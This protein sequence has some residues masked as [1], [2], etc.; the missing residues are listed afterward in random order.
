[1]TDTGT[2]AVGDFG[3]GGRIIEDTTK[4]PLHRSEIVWSNSEVLVS[5]IPLGVEPPHPI[6]TNYY[7]RAFNVFV[8]ARFQLY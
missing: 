5:S 4:G 8:L 2:D 1:V 6:F 3:L 7:V